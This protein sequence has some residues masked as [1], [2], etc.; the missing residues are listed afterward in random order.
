M[1]I[2]RQPID[3]APP[4]HKEAPEPM[5]KWFIAEHPMKELQPV[6]DIF[7]DAATRIVGTIDPGVERTVALR[8]LVEAKDAAIRAFIC[9]FE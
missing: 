3:L 2:N 1:E 9:P 7:C 8:K 4:Q 6:C 5:M